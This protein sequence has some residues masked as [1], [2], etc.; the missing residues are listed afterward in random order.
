MK[1]IT[2]ATAPCSWGVWYAD[3]TPS[4]TPS[5]NAKREVISSPESSSDTYS[6]SSMGR[7]SSSAR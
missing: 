2:I 4:G 1:Q 3:G 6:C 7:Y 5:A